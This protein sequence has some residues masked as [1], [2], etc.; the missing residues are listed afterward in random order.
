MKS[1]K[2][3]AKVLSLILVLTMILTLG[4]CKK[5]DDKTATDTAKTTVSAEKSTSKKDKDADK[6]DKD[7]DKKDKDEDKDKDS[8]KE[9]E[10][11]K[12]EKEDKEEKTTAKKTYTSAE[13]LELY[14]SAANKAKSS[15]ASVNCDYE[16]ITKI[17]GEIPSLYESFGFKEGRTNNKYNS[18]D[19]F[20]V[21]NQS[22]ACNLTAADIKSASVTD[23]GSSKV[24]TIYVKDDDAGTYSHSKKCV[25][26]ISIPIGKW[27]CK[28]VVLRGTINDKGQMTNL[29]YSMPVYVTQ[30]SDAFAF[31]LEQSWSIRW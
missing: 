17:S 5:S 9:K 23:N 21:E 3:L 14:K 1:S 31:K 28:G 10:E 8:D 24:V 11:E 26:T 25:S 27:T 12:T 30:G 29:Y 16:T 20:P 19:K 13:A 6:K 4:A 22:Y 7:A 15:A 18:K 2:T